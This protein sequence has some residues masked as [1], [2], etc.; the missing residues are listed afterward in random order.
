MEKNAYRNE[1]DRVRYTAEGRESLVDALMEARTTG[2]SEPAEPRRRFHW[3]RGA[4]AAVLAAVV[5]LGTATAAVGLPRSLADWFARQWADTTGGAMSEDQAALIDRLTQAV[6]VSETRGDVTVTLDSLTRGNSGVWLLLELRGA[7][8]DEWLHF[9]R[10]DL[11]FQPDPDTVKTPGSYGLSPKFAGIGEDGVYRLL[12]Q[13]DISLIGEDSLLKGY[14]GTLLLR[15][16]YLGEDLTQDEELVQKGTWELRF[17]LEP[18]E[19]G[20]LD[21][22]SRRVPARDMETRELAAAETELRNVQVSATDIRYTQSRAEQ[23]LE[24]LPGKLVLADGTEIAW[25]SGGSRWTSERED[26]EW[27]SVYCWQQPVD[28]RQAAALRFGD[29]EIPLN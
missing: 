12:I 13:Y 10:M 15:D 11:T 21:L 28:L 16:L 29:R 18:A 19:D 27:A 2:A 3:T 26:G 8:R 24:P 23:T 9:D 25:G 22:G 14:E 20:F 1:L 5:L 6:G 7:D 17:T 4:A